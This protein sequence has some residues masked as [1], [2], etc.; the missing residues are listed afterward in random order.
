VN[1]FVGCAKE[2]RTDVVMKFDEGNEAR[3]P[4]NSDRQATAGN[5][6]QNVLTGE[7]ITAV[8]ARGAPNP[9]FHNPNSAAD[10]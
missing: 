4:R 3:T 2:A 9:A 8:S 6:G 5:G 7:L 10:S 1:Y